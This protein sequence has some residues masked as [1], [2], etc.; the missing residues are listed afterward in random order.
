MD[1]SNI[2]VPRFRPRRL[3]RTQGLRSL[4]RETRLSEKSLVYPLFVVEDTDLKREIPGLPGQYHYSPDR[5]CE[6]VSESLEHGV[7]SFL[8]FGLPAGKDDIGSGAW[9]ENGIVQQGVRAIRDQFPEVTIITDVCLCEYTSHGHCGPLPQSVMDDPTTASESDLR[10]AA[11]GPLN[12][13]TIEL[14]AK[15]AVSQ[16]LAGA[17]IVAPSAMMDGQI[18]AIRQGLDDAGLD[19]IPVMSYSAKYASAF[20]GPFR[21][22]AGSAPA[23]GNRKGYQ[24]DPHNAR[25]AIRESMIDEDEGADFLMVKPA[26]SYLDIISTLRGQTD[27]PIAAYSVSGEYSMIKAAAAAGYIDEKAIVDET[28]ISV[29]RAG[30]DILITYYAKEIADSIAAGD[31][32]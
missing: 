14:L 13:A 27:L 3:R 11:A 29:F 6:A 22:A 25:E 4:V 12:D 26:L 1:T 9:A 21:E 31:I 5:I 28:A 2:P 23:F 15:T 24:M 20:Y 16:A 19:D 17:D 32:G 10:E 7:V 8:I 18:A 30:A